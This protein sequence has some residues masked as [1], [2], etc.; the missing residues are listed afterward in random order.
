MMI[1]TMWSLHEHAEIFMR[2]KIAPHE[3]ICST[4][5]GQCPRRPRQI[6]CMLQGGLHWIK[7]ISDDERDFWTIHLCNHLKVNSSPSLSYFRKFSGHANFKVPRT[8]VENLWKRAGSHF[9]W[10]LGSVYW[11][12]IMVCQLEVIGRPLH[13]L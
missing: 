5:V 12:T 1:H 7:W 2:S 11:Q 9:T 3:N 10:K 6:S 13:D 8:V 4:D